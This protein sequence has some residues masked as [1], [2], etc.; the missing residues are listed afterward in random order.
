MK[1]LTITGAAF[2]LLCF[3]MIIGQVD[4]TRAHAKKNGNRLTYDANIQPLLKER[5]GQCHDSDPSADLKLTTYEGVMAGGEHGKVVIPGKSKESN[6]YLKLTTDPPFGKQM[7]KKGDKLSEEQMNMIAQWIDEG[8]IKREEGM[9]LDE[10]TQMSDT[11]V[12]APADLIGFKEHIQPILKAKCAKCHDA[13][14]SGDLYLM[15]YEGIMKGGEHGIVV[16]GGNSKESNLYLKL[17]P[18]PPFG[19]QMPRKGDKLTEEEM[20]LIAKWIDGG[21]KE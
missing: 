3:C 17:T 16:V 4:Q 15:T 8:A 20:L 12:T 1:T 19:K 14:P 7:P 18:S 11:I 6:L 21:A 5:C 9:N 10:S 2:I 13:D